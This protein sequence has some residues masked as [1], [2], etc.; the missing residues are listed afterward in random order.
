MNQIVCGAN[1]CKLRRGAGG[2]E[3]EGLSINLGLVKHSI[4]TETDFFKKTE[5]LI[6]I[7]DDLDIW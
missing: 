5:L 3:V 6:I 7:P 4:P 2:G 1:N